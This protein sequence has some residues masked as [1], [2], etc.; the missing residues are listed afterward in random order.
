MI[1]EAGEIKIAL[2]ESSP[3]I[4]KEFFFRK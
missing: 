2:L 3:E 4:E 1:T